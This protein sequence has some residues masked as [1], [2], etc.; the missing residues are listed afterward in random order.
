MSGTSS[1]RI[2]AP[3][4]LT[5]DATTTLYSVAKNRLDFTLE[6][7]TRVDGRVIGRTSRQPISGARIVL[8]GEGIDSQHTRSAPR[9]RFRF[10][11]VRQ[12]PIRLRVEQTQ[13]VPVVVETVASPEGEVLIEIE[14]DSGLAFGGRVLDSE[15]SPLG[16]ALITL[17]GSGEATSLLQRSAVTGS[18]GEFRFAGLL[19]GSYLLFLP[20]VGKTPRA[21]TVE[22]E[23]DVSVTDYELLVGE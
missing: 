1:V 15:G 11:C 2:G 17:K 21:L 20:P 12:G 7:G 9:G 6:R 19:L 3:G 4:Y 14:I 10:E 8:G 23:L 5:V 13:F 22:V 16:A 18:D